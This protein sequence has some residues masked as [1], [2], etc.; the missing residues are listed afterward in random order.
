[1]EGWVYVNGFNKLYM[2]SNSG[3]LNRIGQVITR[4]N[5]TKVYIRGR[6]MKII[7]NKQGYCSINLTINNKKSN[8]NFHRLVA[9]HF[10]PNPDNKP[11][12]N[13]KNGIKTDNRVENLEWCT[14]SEN[15]KHAFD[16]GLNWSYRG[17]DKKNSKLTNEQVLEI[18]KKYVPQKNSCPMLALEYG[19]SQYTIRSIVR[20]ETWVHI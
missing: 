11:C 20:R 12:V 1:M 6:E 13:H 3:K 15:S 14:R 16:T 17:E 9:T 8:L 7:V 5:G 19:V 18:R 10:I 4:K 2:V